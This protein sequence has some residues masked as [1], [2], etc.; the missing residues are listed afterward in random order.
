MALGNKNGDLVKRF[1]ANP[2]QNLSLF[3]TNNLGQS[4]VYSAISHIKRR[5]NDINAD[6]VLGEKSDC[7]MIGTCRIDLF[8]RPEDQGVIGDDQIR[9]LTHRRLGGLQ[10]HIMRNKNFP[11][12][13]PAFDLHPY[14]IA[15]Q[16]QIQ[17]GQA[18]QNIQRVL[19]G[20]FH[21][22]WIIRYIGLS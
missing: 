12:R 8:K 11:N 21:I 22:E 16:C 13:P 2:I 9:F 4:I 10:A 14:R 5:V 7:L 20:G 3:E 19:R 17:R 18:G 6:F 1:H 15:G